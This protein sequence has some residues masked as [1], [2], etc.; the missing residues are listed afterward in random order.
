MFKLRGRWCASLCVGIAIVL[1]LSVLAQGDEFRHAIELTQSGKL[2]EAELA[3]NELAK[4]H[5]KSAAVHAALGIVLA[6]EGKFDNA[7]AE[8]RR[9]L[10]LNPREPDVSMNLGLAEFKAGR[11][12]EAIEPLLVARNSKP[13]DTRSGL[14]L[15]MSYYGTRS[16]VKA[17]PYLQ[18]AVDADQTNM[19]LHQV[20]AQSCFWSANYPCAMTQYKSILTADPNSV[21]AHMLLGQAL[22]TMNRPADAIA[23]LETAARIAPTEPNVHFELGYLY[24]TGHD[25]EKAAFQFEAELKNNPENAQ[26]A[27]Y[28]G[29][30]K[31]RTDDDAAA[32]T[33]L[34]KAVKLQAGI[35]IAYFDLGQIYAKQK[36]NPEALQAFL[37]AEKLDPNDADAHYRLA[38]IYM[39]LGDKQKA[40]T[41][42]TK[43]KDL[44]SKATDTLIQKVSGGGG[45]MPH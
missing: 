11:F 39:A 17:V 33:L 35:R 12:A 16:Y 1:H 26:A 29:D 42:F 37:Q 19:E 20:L 18:A 34:T 40:Q 30:V 6:Q 8:Y 7:I 32:E 21:Q 27:A 14:L 41:E 23:E 45:A 24:F 28:L 5:P 13:Q 25:Y 36:R 22:D 9:A 4:S 44:H 2:P 31:L 3:W 10:A 15:G 43:T 38:R